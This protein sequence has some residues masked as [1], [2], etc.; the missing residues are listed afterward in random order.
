MHRFAILFILVIFSGGSVHADESHNLEPNANVCS[1]DSNWFQVFQSSCVQG[2]DLSNAARAERPESRNQ[3]VLDQLRSTCNCI[4]NENTSLIQGVVEDI[5]KN[6]RYESIVADS[7]TQ[8]C[9]DLVSANL[10]LREDLSYY[11]PA[12]HPQRREI[13][14]RFN[15]RSTR[16]DNEERLCEKSSFVKENGIQFKRT[17]EIYADNSS[18]TSCIGSRNLKAFFKVPQFNDVFNFLSRSPAAEEPSSWN[19]DVIRNELARLTMNIS[20]PDEVG[21]NVVFEDNQAIWGNTS[22]EDRAKIRLYTAQLQF[23]KAN[24]VLRNIMKMNN[25]NRPEITQRQRDMLKRFKSTVASGFDQRCLASSDVHSCKTSF[26]KNH[27]FEDLQAALRDAFIQ[28][29]SSEDGVFAR[30]MEENEN[31]AFRAFD[32][33]NRSG[34]I[35]SVLELGFDENTCKQSMFSLDENPSGSGSELCMNKLGFICGAM[36]K[37]PAEIQ[38]ANIPPSSD[39]LRKID[40]SNDQLENEA[41]NKSICE[42]AYRSRDN[43]RTETY[44]QYESRICARGNE[45]R[46][47]NGQAKEQMRQL[48]LADYLAEY[49]TGNDD[50]MYFFKKSPMTYFS[51]ADQRAISSSGRVTDALGNFNVDLPPGW[52]TRTQ[53][54]SRTDSSSAGSASASSSQNGA[55]RD[56]NDFNLSPAGQTQVP[57]MSSSPISSSPIS[58]P[59]PLFN[60]P[61]DVRDARLERDQRESAVASQEAELAR[62]REEGASQERLRSM[63]RELAS[64]RSSLEESGSRYE[65]LLKELSKKPSAPV[66]PAP[67]RSIASAAEASSSAAGRSQ[68]NVVNS[69]SAA[70]GRGVV[71]DIGPSSVT[72]SPSQGQQLSS[73]GSFGAGVGSAGASLSSAASQNYNAALNDRYLSNSSG[74]DTSLVVSASRGISSRVEIPVSREDFTRLQSGG[75]ESASAQI[76]SAIENS[77]A[78]APVYL[79]SDSSQLVAFQDNGKTEILPL[80][81]YQRRFSPGRSIASEPETARSATLQDLQGTLETGN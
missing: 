52:N 32:Q 65:Q 48:I 78:E 57:F 33:Q 39:L 56:Q 58:S 73:G 25:V 50:L 40:F 43:R 70:I 30:L 41:F 38:V 1:F 31:S 47:E 12:D 14:Q 81:E 5:S 18:P 9:R 55:I 49:N 51:Q 64:L 66:A 46:C 4:K 77:V 44:V 29:S 42:T 36:E 7:K 28:E 21:Y 19:V 10:E 22:A 16:L 45:P 23:L 3:I 2:I 76:R 62:A 27:S 71:P 6:I 37:M 67:E 63:E 11:F 17:S 24:P 34:L 15:V 35:G 13:N 20:L 69:P 8:A 59:A 54:A 53:T 26:L 60:E 72:N 80:V 75:L 61:E 79:V 68:T 74:A